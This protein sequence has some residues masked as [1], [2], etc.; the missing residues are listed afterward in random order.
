MVEGGDGLRGGGYYSVGWDEEADW[1][2]FHRLSEPFLSGD[3]GY[4]PEVDPVWTLRST[5]RPRRR[6][7]PDSTLRRC[8]W[9]R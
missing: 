7:S 2:G 6:R 5:P 8:R 9:R 4:C 1:Y 3:E